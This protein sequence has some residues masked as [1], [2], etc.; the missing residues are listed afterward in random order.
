M[1][2]LR[3]DCL[4]RGEQALEALCASNVSSRIWLLRAKRRRPRSVFFFYLVRVQLSVIVKTDP[5]LVI[6][7]FDFFYLKY[8]LKMVK[9]LSKGMVK[10]W[11]S[12]HHY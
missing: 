3:Y 8:N 4:G 9:C 6:F 12:G 5:I 2:I 7:S 1:L 10:T 11:N